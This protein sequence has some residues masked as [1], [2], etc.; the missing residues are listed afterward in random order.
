MPV[1]DVRG[2]P[3]SYL[4]SGASPTVSFGMKPIFKRGS[5]LPISKAAPRTKPKGKVS[6]QT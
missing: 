6:T 5:E 1:K 2:T 4:N 3:E